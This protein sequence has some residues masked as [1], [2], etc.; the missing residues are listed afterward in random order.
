MKS[1]KR[2]FRQSYSPIGLEIS[3]DSV[4]MIQVKRNNGQWNLHCVVQRELQTREHESEDIRNKLAIVIKK[5]MKDHSFYGRQ[6][7]SA[8]SNREVD[9]LPV[10]IPA[11]D[12]S[13]MEEKILENARTRLSYAVEQAV[14]DYLPIHALQETD[15]EKKSFWVIASQRP[16]V[17]NHL[18]IIN[19]AGLHSQA[20][21]IQPCAI[22]RSLV[23]SGYEVD[24]KLLLIH[25]NDRES[26]FLLIEKAGFLAQRICLKGFQDLADKLQKSLQMDRISSFRL[27]SDHGFI[28][29]MTDQKD[30][31]AINPDSIDRTVH[32]I[33]LPI[34]KEILE[35]LKNFADYC[36]AEIREVSVERICL[37][38]KACMVRNLDRMIEKSTEMKTEIMN[39]LMSLGVDEIVQSHMDL[40]QG[41][42]FSVPLGLSLRG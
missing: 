26:I 15:E 5:I 38:G 6:V 41:S 23:E 31:G 3:E 34:F 14:I 42:V 17:E 35:G 39:P 4:R 27:L 16:L 30:R 11:S 20:I 1:M 13:G 24:K 7:V 8:L 2:F 21:D 28:D 19:G 32:E 9:I 37:S 12:E 29:P 18:A 40:K 33:I 10:R 22:M 36:H 25:M